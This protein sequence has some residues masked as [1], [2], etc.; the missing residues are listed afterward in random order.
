MKFS[1][2]ARLSLYFFLT[3]ITFVYHRYFYY[4]VINISERMPRDLKKNIYVILKIYI[5]FYT[6]CY[7]LFPF[8]CTSITGIPCQT[9]H[10]CIGAWQSSQIIHSIYFYILHLF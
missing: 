5:Y 3:I 1:I 4:T 2:L 8:S 6:L 10:Y 9:Q 7:R